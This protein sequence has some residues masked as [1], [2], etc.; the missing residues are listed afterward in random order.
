[1]D[2]QA[3][4][5][6]RAWCLA[7]LVVLG[8]AETGCTTAPTR[9]DARAVDA[10]VEASLAR[11]AADV[12]GA[13][14]LLR[15]AYGALVFPDVIEGAFWGGAQYGEGALRARGKTLDY[16]NIAAASF[17]AQFGAQKKDIIL[18]FMENSALQKFRNSSGWQVGLD[19]AVT[20]VTV[21]AE[22]S[23]G[24]RT[25]HQ[26]ILAFVIDQ[27]GLMAGVSLEGSKITRM[28]PEAS[29]ADA[30]VP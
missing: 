30:G 16:Y 29:R 21:G 8:L 2:D 14:K 9:A 12:N 6:V 19:G 3:I 7:L 15:T 23:I 1:M 13:D 24:T 27:K 17:G 10:R 25:Y 4:A 28:K 11:L 5:W 20:L 18:L 22:G 26:P